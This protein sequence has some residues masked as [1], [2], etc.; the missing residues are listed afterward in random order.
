MVTTPL[1][2]R[3]Y[4]ILEKYGINCILFYTSHVEGVYRDP[5]HPVLLDLLISGQDVCRDDYSRRGKILVIDRGGSTVEKGQC[6]YYIGECPGRTVL[7]HEELEDVVNKASFPYI[8]VAPTPDTGVEEAAIDAVLVLEV[9][10]EMLW[11]GQMIIASATARLGRRFDELAGDNRVR[12]S[13]RSPADVAWELEIYNVIS[14]VPGKGSTQHIPSY[15]GIFVPLTRTIYTRELIQS[16]LFWSRPI[17]LGGMGN[18]RPHRLIRP[19]L[20]ALY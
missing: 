5:L 18:I 11:D 17:N 9:I 20:N 8:I 15:S 19:L 6:H 2:R 16:M 4:P 10:R 1:T 3:S 13:R 7:A 14:P 12:K